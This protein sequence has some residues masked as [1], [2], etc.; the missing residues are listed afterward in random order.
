MEVL[1]V[2]AVMAVGATIAIPQVNKYRKNSANG[3]A[4]GAVQSAY[5]VAQEYYQGQDNP[6]GN[7]TFAGFNATIAAG[8][9]KK[10]AWTN[11]TDVSAT[12]PRRI[13]IRPAP[14]S[15]SPTE[16]PLVLCNASKAYTYCVKQNTATSASGETSLRWGAAAGVNVATAVTRTDHATCADSPEEAE[17][18]ADS[19]GVS[20]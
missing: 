15:P 3:E 16:A 1:V 6:Y 14:A 7:L 12:D 11:G 18:L 20:C 8:I 17:R 10:F 4:R 5:E 13:S 2:I 19:A 9:D